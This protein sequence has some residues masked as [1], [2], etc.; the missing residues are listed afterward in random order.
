MGGLFTKDEECQISLKQRRLR[1]ACMSGDQR[2]VK[3]L[4]EEQQPW[5]WAFLC[6]TGFNSQEQ[7]KLCLE[8]VYMDD[9]ARQAIHYVAAG[10][11]TS[12]LKHGLPASMHSG[13]RSAPYD[14]ERATLLTWLLELPNIEINLNFEDAWW[15]T[16]LHLSILSGSTEVLEV[17]IT[18][19]SQKGNRVKL[20]AVDDMGRTPLDLAVLT[21]QWDIVKRLVRVGALESSGALRQAREDLK[22]VLPESTA[23][24]LQ[25]D[26]TQSS[27]NS[28]QVASKLPFG[29]GKLMH[30]M[31]GV[32]SFYDCELDNHIH[33]SSQPSSSNE[34]E[35]EE[36]PHVLENQ[37]A[38]FQHRQQ[39]I[40]HIMYTCNVDQ[41]VALKLFRESGFVIDK[42]I[43]IFFSEKQTTDNHMESLKGNDEQV[44]IKQ[45]SVN[46][47][48]SG[49]IVCYEEQG[50]ECKIHMD[51]EHIV[52]DNCW[53]GIMKARMDE[54]DVHM[55][56]CPH[57]ECFAVPPAHELETLLTKQ[58][59]SKF[60]QL[61][62]VRYVDS[63]P[64]VRWCPGT[65]CGNS[66]ALDPSDAALVLNGYGLEV[67]C[68]CGQQ[69]C[70]NCR[71]S[72]HEPATCKQM[73]E[74]AKIVPKAVEERSKE[75]LQKC[76]KTCT[77][78]GASIQR[79]GGCNHMIC[80]VCRHH[81]CWACGGDWN[82]HGPL[83]GGYYYCNRM[84][85]IQSSH[86]KIVGKVVKTL[87][88]V[89]KK[90]LY[91]LEYYIQK[92]DQHLHN[93]REFED[94]AFRLRQLLELGVPEDQEQENNIS[95]SENKLKTP[96]SLIC[97]SNTSNLRQRKHSGDP[98]QQENPAESQEVIQ[99]ESSQ[100][101][102]PCYL[103]STHSDLQYFEQWTKQVERSK[104]LLRNCYIMLYFM[105]GGVRRRYL[106]HIVHRLETV[107]EQLVAPI[108]HAPHKLSM[109]TNR[110]NNF[111]NRTKQGLKWCT[112][113]FFGY[114]FGTS[115]IDSL[116]RDQYSSMDGSQ[117]KDQFYYVLALQ[118][119]SELIVKL[120]EAAETQCQQIRG[121][122]KE[123]LFVQNKTK[124]AWLD[125]MIAGFSDD[126][127]QQD[128]LEGEGERG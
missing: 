56:R 78:C 123:G 106:E 50:G 49:C 31:L 94:V 38:V 114:E 1:K 122:T 118:E 65:G 61:L 96:C 44:E 107:V 26:N 67:E 104:Y 90:Y 41:L 91:N 35:R 86:G 115:L 54:G 76:T 20:D 75:W 34:L 116:W 124:Y 21:Q 58:Q 25:L 64:L 69:F 113:I 72:P 84:P 29:L 16:P 2:T 14:K 99:Q 15:Q 82:L 47:R 83:S 71:G 73:E 66:V 11:S 36:H 111:I 60:E 24:R 81:F 119:R 102:V 48:G 53:R 19:V 98:S 10:P 62:A 37:E 22:E 85:Q 97:G 12:H 45:K 30:R 3:A 17:I 46:S 18:S 42:A 59:W 77:G 43:E 7:D 74:W 68:S 92:H 70:W 110:T 125:R 33:R 127:Q 121:G 28:P 63:S 80:P 109:T 57:P 120:I 5:W 39:A 126:K 40:E 95:M 105:S 108:A 117:L 27:Y 93:K 112:S 87:H 101:V 103:S 51:C 13:R 100:Q 55:I 8:Y 89:A 88:Q 23:L 4:I 128:N 52:C 79:N 9:G 32:D 6:V